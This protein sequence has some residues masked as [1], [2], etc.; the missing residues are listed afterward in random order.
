MKRRTARAAQGRSM[1]QRYTG[2]AREGG[3][4]G[5]GYLSQ[6]AHRLHEHPEVSMVGVIQQHVHLVQNQP[7][8]GEEREGGGEGG[9]EGGK[10]GKMNGHI[11]TKEA[12]KIGLRERGRRKEGE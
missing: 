3:R 8:E 2:R 7:R 5:G 1:G 9:R 12:G 4:E 10:E 11:E 6:G